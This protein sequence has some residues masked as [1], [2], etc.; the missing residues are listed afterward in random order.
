VKEEDLVKP[1]SSCD[2]STKKPTDDDIESGPVVKPSCDTTK[3]PTDGIEGGPG[4]L[5]R[6]STSTT[7]ESESSSGGNDEEDYELY[8]PSVDN[9]DTFDAE[10]G[11]NAPTSTLLDFRQ[12]DGSF[13][14]LPASRSH[15]KR[16]VETCCAIC[17]TDYEVT[18]YEVGD[19]VV[20]S[21]KRDCPHVFHEEC[22]M[23]WLCK[24]KKRCPICRHWFV[25]STSIDDK[26]AIT[27]DDASLTG[28]ETLPSEESGSTYHSSDSE[29]DDPLLNNNSNNV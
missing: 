23:T 19:K 16:Q 13:L 14:C 7:L 21:C 12:G 11:V 28:G 18:D 25:P 9:M 20:Y 1:L 26:K 2:T 29:E 15:P 22:I 8:S 4:E 5:A 24:G 6:V 3:K 17:I 10:L 27:Y